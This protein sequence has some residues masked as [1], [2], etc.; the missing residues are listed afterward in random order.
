MQRALT[1]RWNE[2]GKH[3]EMSLVSGPLHI[4]TIQKSRKKIN[5]I[6]SGEEVLF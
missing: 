2:N 3:A 5:P 1:T 6:R 4:S